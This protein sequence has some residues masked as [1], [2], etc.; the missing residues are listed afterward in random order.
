MEKL[1]FPPPGVHGISGADAFFLDIQRIAQENAFYFWH[2]TQLS[3]LSDKIRERQR[4]IYRGN[5]EKLAQAFRTLMADGILREES[6]PGEYG[7]VIDTL[8]L[9]GIYWTPFC[10][11]RQE[12]A[13]EAGYRRQ[14]WSVLFP[15]LTEKGRQLLRETVGT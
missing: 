8:L 11:L 10:G 6:Y 4:A 3:Q 2:H 14:A 5:A 7:L 1:G 12:S 9:S 13:P 15:L